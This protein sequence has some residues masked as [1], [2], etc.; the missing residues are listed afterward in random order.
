M[1]EVQAADGEQL[2][3]WSRWL[4]S[5]LDLEECDIKDAIDGRYRREQDDE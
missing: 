3:I 5:G 1:D 4:R 2:R